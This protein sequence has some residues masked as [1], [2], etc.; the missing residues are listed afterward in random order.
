MS[1]HQGSVWPLFTGWGALAEYRANQPLPAQQ[2]LMQNVD[3]TWAQDPGAVT[4]LLSGDFYVPMGRS[5]SHQLW[6]SAMVLTP[7]LRGL[8]GINLDAATHTITVNPHLPATWVE[9]RVSQ[10]HL[11][12][13]PVNLRLS[14]EKGRLRITAQSP[15]GRPFNSPIHLRSDAVGT[16][17]SGTNEISVPLPAI[18]ISQKD[19]ALPPPGSRPEQLKILSTDYT[20][21]SLTVKVQGQ[22]GTESHLAVTTNQ[23]VQLK[24][25]TADGI[26]FKDKDVALHFP[27]GQGWQTL[28]LTLTW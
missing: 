1:Y 3:L 6:S 14:R 24:L 22:P 25:T 26:E 7:T 27:P 4:E 23:P 2:M 21:H 8:F 9:S 11:G 20:S 5:T 28:T 12:D 13:Q 15:D 18:E 16:T 19:H 10:L 17:S